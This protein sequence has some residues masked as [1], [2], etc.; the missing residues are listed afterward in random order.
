MNVIHMT[1]KN[2]EPPS[3][4]A[5]T[6]DTKGVS[7]ESKEISNNSGL[8][9]VPVVPTAPPEKTGIL[10]W[11]RT[12]FKNK[13]DT[14]LREAIEEFIED[15]ASDNDEL[16]PTGTHEKT[17]ISNV[18]KL[19]DLHVV[20]AMIPRAD[21]VAIDSSISPQELLAKFA[22]VQYSRI[23]V[24]KEQLDDV[25]GIIHIKD[26]L[27][28]LA[29]GKP[30]ELNELIREVPIISPSMSILDLMLEMR[31][32]RRHMA[33]VIDE[34]GGIDGLVTMGDIIEEIT[35]HIEDEHGASSQPRIKHTK[36]GSL[37]A[38]AR[39]DVD[40]FEDEFGKI[41]TEEEREDSDTLGGLVFYMA[42]RVPA[43]GEVLTHAS[44]MT[45][46]ILDAN[47]RRVNQI[48]IKNIP[49]SGNDQ[50]SS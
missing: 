23:P 4:R 14:S 16:D 43:R 48:K 24:Y 46:E 44:G 2:E 34:Y 30:L 45:L 8:G 33:M 20:N 15:N 38:D 39:Y 27:S 37:I 35:G 12:G 40:E 5:A 3:R 11:I 9:H 36:D 26:V 32:T 18:L 41:L 25:L 13:P 49:T 50:T 17:L 19:R 29:Q 6:T 10:S 22:D 28:T 47:Q 1:E 31:Q 21:I 42:G 7:S